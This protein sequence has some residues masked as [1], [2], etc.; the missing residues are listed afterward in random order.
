MEQ[1]GKRT[2][3]ALL[4]VRLVPPVLLLPLLQLVGGAP[5]GQ[6]LY[7]MP[8]SILQGQWGTG[9]GAS[10][11]ESLAADGV[12]VGDGTLGFPLR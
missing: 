12:A 7:P 10:L 1:R 5:L 8:A 3:D 2:R 4:G 11:G 9:M 6:R